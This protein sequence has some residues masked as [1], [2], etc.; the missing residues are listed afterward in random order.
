[1]GELVRFF[2]PFFST[3]KTYEEVLN[4]LAGFA[5]YETL[6]IFFFLQ[7]VPAVSNFLQSIEDY[8]RI[9]KAVLAIPYAEVIHPFSLLL[10][11]FVALISYAVKL[12]DQISNFLKI[13]AKFDV[14]HILLPLA[15][16]VGV[17]LTA[18]QKNGVRENR[19]ALMRD[20][21][22][23]YA[24]SRAASPLVDKHDIEHAL[25][26]WSWFWVLVEATVYF[27]V[28]G[29]TA[30]FL[31]STALGITFL[32]VGVVTA[33]AAKLSYRNLW[34]YAFPQIKAISSDTLA[35]TAVRTSFNAL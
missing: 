9:G 27:S 19:H 14:K 34:K 31:S 28:A 22:Y 15:A 20:V 35:S 4:R 8:G 17:S 2:L 29:V 10:A 18:D 5:F 7:D 16:L 32:S 24:S 13:R 21:F 33:T 6:L 11:F 25:N 30:L 1:M 26:V 12:H 3:T 23:R